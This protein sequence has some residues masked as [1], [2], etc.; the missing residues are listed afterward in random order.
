MKASCNRLTAQT[1]GQQHRQQ[2]GTAQMPTKVMTM[3]EMPQ[4][5]QIRGSP[6]NRLASNN[7]SKLDC[8]HHTEI[9]TAHH[10]ALAELTPSRHENRACRSCSTATRQLEGNSDCRHEG[11][12]ARLKGSCTCMPV[13]RLM[14]RATGTLSEPGEAKRVM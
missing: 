8:R 4:G 14:Q 9:M 10:A 7:P 6:K 12:T 1:Q 11:G 13:S 5:K 3:T 2:E